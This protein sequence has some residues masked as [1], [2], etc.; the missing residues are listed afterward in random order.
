MKKILL[1][2][3]L[4]LIPTPSEAVLNVP[5]NDIYAQ[6]Y[7]YLRPNMDMIGGGGGGTSNYGHVPTD[8]TLKDFTT[9][10]GIDTGT[11]ATDASCSGVKCPSDMSCSAGCCVF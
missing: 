1:I 6:Q 11:S 5:D 10:T 7:Q 8:T 9:G 3:L 4:T 2:G